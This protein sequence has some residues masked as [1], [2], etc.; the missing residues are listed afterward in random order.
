LAWAIALAAPLLVA[1][2]SSAVMIAVWEAS[3]RNELARAEPGDQVTIDAGDEI[4]LRV[5]IPADESD[6]GEREYLSGNWSLDSGDAAEISN[7]DYKKG[8]A[9]VTGDSSGNVA[10]SF[11]SD[12]L[13]SDIGLWVSV[14]GGSAAPPP[15][16]VPSPGG[17]SPPQAS[18]TET[19]EVYSKGGTVVTALY[20]G[21]LLRAPDP[22]A[23][24]WVDQVDRGGYRKLLD[25]AQ[26]I[27][28]SNESRVDLYDRDDVSTQER[29]AAIYRHLLGLEPEEVDREEWN[30]AV[31]QVEDGDIAGLVGDVVADRA[32]R[33]RFGY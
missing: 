28:K 29:V 10:L 8:S 24:T 13:E 31:A 6:S 32:F 1:A 12:E 16:T 15:V 2:P 21:V 33:R 17:K 19:L 11:S 14:R 18:E 26:S 9:V 30:E 4:M 3:T 23:Q 5:F 22:S 25:V 7:I 27:A 20:Q